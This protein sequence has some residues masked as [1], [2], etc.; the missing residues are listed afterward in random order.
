MT[1]VV[2]GFLTALGGAAPPIVPEKARF[3]LITDAVD[4]A[5]GPAAALDGRIYFSDIPKAEKPGRILRFDPATGRVSVF[6]SDSGKS[7]GLCFD[8]AGRLVACEGA[9]LGNRR[10]SRYPAELFT[11]PETSV[12]HRA[13]ETVV[14]RFAGK[15]FRAPN[16]LCVDAHGRIWFSD[17]FYVGAEKPEIPERSVYR[18]DPDGS[19]HRV[20]SQPLIQKPNGVEVSPDG[21]TLYVA[22]TNNEM[23]D[24]KPGAMQLVAFTIAGDGTLSAK[25]V[26][27]DFGSETGVDGMTVDEAGNVY[28][29]VRSA[30]RFGITIYSPSGT[31][32]GYLP[33]PAPPTNC[34]FGRGADSGTLYVTTDTGFGRVRL[35][36]R[37]FHLPRQ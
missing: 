37:G 9:D 30:R 12:T 13:A 26:L 11:Q 32:L 8:T 35:N 20:L 14:E 7:N 31:E 18:V 21:K 4:F 5:E 24:G 1:L 29:A 28:A 19:V 3:E 25:R 34:I 17:P 27:A 36:A 2:M 22:D 6:C 15:R 16:D 33:T 10:I 23:V